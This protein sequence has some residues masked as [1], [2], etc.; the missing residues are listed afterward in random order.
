MTFIII[1]ILLLI[2]SGGT[3]I[4]SNLID[5]FDC[6]VV[7]AMIGTLILLFCLVWAGISIF[8]DAPRMLEFLQN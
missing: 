3:F 2:I 7:W 4:V 6:R 5:D 8:N 1:W